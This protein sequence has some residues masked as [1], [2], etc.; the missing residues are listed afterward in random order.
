MGKRNKHEQMRNTFKILVGKHA[1]RRLVEPRLRLHDNFNMINKKSHWDGVHWIQLAQGRSQRQPSEHGNKTFSFHNAKNFLTNNSCTFC[2]WC[3]GF[4]SCPWES[5]YILNKG[6][7]GLLSPSKAGPCN[8]RP[9][10]PQNMY[11]CTENLAWNENSR[12]WKRLNNFAL[13][14]NVLWPLA[15]PCVNGRWGVISPTISCYSQLS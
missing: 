8:V 4:N 9:A 14:K 5:S 11:W 10:G 2:S 6:L 15:P 12:F 1:K 13:G 3:P 7:P